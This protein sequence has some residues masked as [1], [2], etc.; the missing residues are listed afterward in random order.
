MAATHEFALLNLRGP[1]LK[2]RFIFRRNLLLLY[3]EA[4]NMKYKPGDFPHTL[5]RSDREYK[6]N[7]TRSLIEHFNVPNNNSV[8]LL[9]KIYFPYF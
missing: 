9:Y 7:F 4:E 1:N 6:N 2:N 5:S 3:R 8:Q